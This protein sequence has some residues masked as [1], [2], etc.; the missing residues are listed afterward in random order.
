MPGQKPL[1]RCAWCII[2]GHRA[3]FYGSLRPKLRPPGPNLA[4]K[5]DQRLRRTRGA[6]E[7]DLSLLYVS[8]GPQRP[9][10]GH[11]RLRHGQIVP[12]PKCEK[13]LV[14]P[15]RLF[16]TLHLPPG[17]PPVVIP[18]ARTPYLALRGMGG[19]GCCHNLALDWGGTVT[20]S[21]SSS[22]VPPP[23]ADAPSAGVSAAPRG[24]GGGSEAEA[25]S[26]V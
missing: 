12:P 3:A 22:I 26:S 25:R 1:P 20:A 16:G 9:P 21:A 2:R 11:R 8:V 18:M 13:S 23:E 7:P 4:K 14:G 19:G 10:G 17:N 15:F 5:S 6:A 24:E